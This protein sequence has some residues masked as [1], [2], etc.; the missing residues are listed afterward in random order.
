MTRIYVTR[1]NEKGFSKLIKLPYPNLGDE[2]YKFEINVVG[3]FI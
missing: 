2:W 3:K 1:L